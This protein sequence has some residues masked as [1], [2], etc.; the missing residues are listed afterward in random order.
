VEARFQKYRG[1]IRLLYMYVREA[2][3]VPAFAP[4]GSTVDIGWSHA[5]ANT[6]SSAERAQRARWLANDFNLNFPWIIDDMDDT[7]HSDF[8]PFGFYVGWLVDC[9]GT[10]LLHEPWGWAT[11]STQWCG[12]PLADFENLEAYL[13]AYLASPPPCYRGPED[14]PS[15]S[16]IPAAAHTRGIARSNWVTDLSIANPSD[17]EARV[18]L[19]LQPWN[20]ED[21]EAATK[22]L[23]LAARESIEYHDVLDSVFAASG[24]ATLRIESDSPVVTVSRTFHDTSD[25]TYGLFMRALPERYAIGGRVVGHLLMLEESP[26][27][28]TNIGLT[29]LGDEEVDAEVEIFTADGASLGA[30]VITV[31]AWGGTQKN[32]MIRDFTASAVEGARATV[33]VLTPGGRVMA[34]AS[35][36]DNQ[37]NDPTYVEPIVNIFQ[38]DLNLPA[39]AKLQG[40][41]SSNWVTDI[42]VTN[43]EGTTVTASVDRWQRDHSGGDPDSAEL[44]LAPRQSLVLRDVLKTLF[45]TDGAAALTVHGSRGLMAVGRTYNDTPSGSFGHSLPGLDITGDQLLRGGQVGHLLMLEESGVDGRRTN[46]GLVNTEDLPIEVELTFFNE[47]GAFIGV[48]DQDLPANGFVQLDRVLRSI[49]SSSERNA[50]AEVRLTSAVGS[51]VAYATSI[52]NRTGDPVMQVAWPMEETG[53]E[54]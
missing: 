39:T 52:D 11:P 49:S 40:A 24:A 1:Q 10:V 42:V 54:H 9:D 48:L 32:R 37:T 7:M 36:I 33:R 35:V 53:E 18:S 41:G 45:A 15:V 50:R 30:A 5:S 27:F 4:C 6:R 29:N 44:V 17:G 38:Q 51:V 46:I 43:L 28:R 8:W 47:A 14:S 19:H 13:D 16:I 26:E 25:G 21:D 3:P 23:T 34:Y 12:L 22:E 20:L 2:H 31:P